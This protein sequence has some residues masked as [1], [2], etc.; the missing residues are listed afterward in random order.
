VIGNV[1]GYHGIYIVVC[2]ALT[3]IKQSPYNIFRPVH[4]QMDAAFSSSSLASRYLDSRLLGLT[5]G[6]PGVIAEVVVYFSTPVTNHTVLDAL[7]A[8]VNE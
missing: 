6:E 1:F 8:T 5:D 4:L 3:L 7:R 2:R